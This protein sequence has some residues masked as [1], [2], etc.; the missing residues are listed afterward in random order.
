[1]PLDH[2]TT[3]S[4]GGA[5]Q[6]TG[7][8]ELANRTDVWAYCDN[9]VLGPLTVTSNGTIAL[10]RAT[11]AVTYGLQPPWTARL[12][13]LRDKLARDVPFKPPAR[14]YE[15]ELALKSTGAIT[16]ATNGAVHRP[17]PLQ[18][19]GGIYADAGPL[20]TETGGASALPM[21]ERLFT[22]NRT[23]SGLLGFSRTPYVELSRDVPVPVHVK[24]VRMEVVMRD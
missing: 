19:M 12:Q 6:V 15:V 4:L 7:A 2:A 18:T 20:A 16:I 9:E 14:I 23:V 1:M 8:L 24:S 5:N 3:R 21:L 10:G 11:Q 13:V 22:G 17:V